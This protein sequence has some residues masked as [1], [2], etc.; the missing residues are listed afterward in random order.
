[1][2]S[3]EGLL[4]PSDTSYPAGDVPQ[5]EAGAT[6]RLGL[7]VDSNPQKDSKSSLFQWDFPFLSFWGLLPKTMYIYIH[8]YIVDGVLGKG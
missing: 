6:V 2:D 8:V 5:H 3:N 7:M 1:M 4:A